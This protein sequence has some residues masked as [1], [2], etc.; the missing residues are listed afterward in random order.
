MSS[1]GSS[2]CYASREDALGLALDGIRNGIIMVVWFDIYLRS[3]KRLALLVVII[4][5][6]ILVVV[7]CSRGRSG[8]IITI[9]CFR[10]GIL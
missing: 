7:E 4:I 9:I 2:S 10:G 6:M 8:G 3:R 5:I 1:L